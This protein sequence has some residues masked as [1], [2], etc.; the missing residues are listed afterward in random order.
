M[1]LPPSCTRRTVRTRRFLPAVAYIAIIIVWPGVCV[2][3]ITIGCGNG[4]TPL[5]QTIAKLD[6]FITVIPLTSLP[7]AGCGLVVRSDRDMEHGL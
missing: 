7:D 5:S 2:L 1:I 3:P 4:E 6:H